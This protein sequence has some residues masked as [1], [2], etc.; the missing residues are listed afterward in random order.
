M[1]AQAMADQD[2][3]LGRRVRQDP[4]KSR[5]GLVCSNHRRVP[6]VLGKVCDEKRWRNGAEFFAA[7]RPARAAIPAASPMA[8]FAPT[9]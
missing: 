4:G 8:C 3:T 5:A 7:V 6:G 9:L 1:G 2:V